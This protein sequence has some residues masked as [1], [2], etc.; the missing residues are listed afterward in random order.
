MLKSQ[1]WVDGD[2]DTEDTK[3]LGGGNNRVSF[4]FHHAGRPWR[5]A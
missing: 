2:S 1:K 4:P 3:Q 5:K